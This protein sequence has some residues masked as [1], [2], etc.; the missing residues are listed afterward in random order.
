MIFDHQSWKSTTLVFRGVV[1]DCSRLN[2]TSAFP[3]LQ[4][5]SYFQNA[6][7]KSSASTSLTGSRVIYVIYTYEKGP[8]PTD[9]SFEVKRVKGGCSQQFIK[10]R[11]PEVTIRGR[12]GRYGVK[13]LYLQPGYQRGVIESGT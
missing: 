2:F 9:V 1:G 6:P 8:T 5:P 13:I 12:Y 11:R 7:K 4:K 10:L 3:T